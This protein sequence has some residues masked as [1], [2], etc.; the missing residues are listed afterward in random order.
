[1]LLNPAHAENSCLKGEVM[2]GQ[3]DQFTRHI[4]S[5]EL[6]NIRLKLPGPLDFWPLAFLWKFHGKQL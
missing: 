2:N 3:Q 5:V 1:M 6:E 4:P